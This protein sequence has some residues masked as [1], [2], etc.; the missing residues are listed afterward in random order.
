V[1]KAK[2][3]LEQSTPFNEF[4][5]TV[6]G[7]FIAESNERHYSAGEV[8][9]HELTEGDEIY[10]ILEGGIRISVELAS[11]H[12]MAEEIEGG[13]G[14]L[15]GEGRFISEGPRPATVTATS[16][17]TALVWDVSAWKKIAD[18]IPEIGYRLAVYAGQVL[19]GR[20]EKLKEH[21]IN[22][23]SWGIE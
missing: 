17:L 15:V 20:V 19:F 12:H 7:R 14:E 9:Y 6:L 13:P 5:D 22:D 18:E 10:F 8:L 16:D 2:A 4:E 21:L 23:I 3:I 11:A 1:S